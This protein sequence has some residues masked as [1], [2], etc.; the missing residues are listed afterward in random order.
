[1][2]EEDIVAMSGEEESV[3]VDDEGEVDVDCD[4]VVIAS[5]C[6]WIDSR[7]ELRRLVLQTKDSVGIGLALSRFHVSPMICEIHYALDEFGTAYHS[8]RI[9]IFPTVQLGLCHGAPI[10]VAP[11][12]AQQRMA[13]KHNASSTLRKDSIVSISR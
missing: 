7:I 5:L 6:A 10:A 11:V 2:V 12:C 4:E 13:L 3:K 8:L 1:L 9:F